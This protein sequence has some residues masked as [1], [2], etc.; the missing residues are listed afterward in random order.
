M[1]TDVMF[2]ITTALLAA[3]VTAVVTIVLLSDLQDHH[4]HGCC[5]LACGVALCIKES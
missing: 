5:Q 3:A 2:I 4:R 1:V